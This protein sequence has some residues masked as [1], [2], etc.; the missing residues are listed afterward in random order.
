MGSSGQWT[1]SFIYN[2]LNNCLTGHNQSQSTPD[3][4]YDAPISVK[5]YMP[6]YEEHQAKALNALREELTEKIGALIQNIRS[7]DHYDAFYDISL[8]AD[9]SVCGCKPKS[10]KGLLRDLEARQEISKALDKEEQE[11]PENIEKLTQVH[12]DYSAQ[13]KKFRIDDRVFERSENSF[14]AVLKSLLLILYSPLYLAGKIA[15]FIPSFISQKVANGLKTDDFRSSFHLVLWLTL[16]IVYYFIGIVVL[17]FVCKPFYLAFGIA[18]ASM[19]L[20]RISLF[21]QF[22]VKRTLKTWRLIFAKSKYPAIVKTLKEQRKE[23]IETVKR[24]VRK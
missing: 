13:L 12:A 14:I 20:G 16:Y 18:I 11:H 9:A 24:L 5:E 7:D 19:F 4:T 3:Y 1:R 8:I 17:C 23:I 21:Y 6:Q 15:N 22:W 10:K 2:T